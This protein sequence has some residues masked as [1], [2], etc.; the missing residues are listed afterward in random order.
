MQRF[1]AAWLLHA[2]VIA[3]ALQHLYYLPPMTAKDGS[4]YTDEE[5]IDFLV[6]QQRMGLKKAVLSRRL[7]VNRATVHRWLDKYG[8][9]ATA[10][11]SDLAYQPTTQL[12]AE[13]GSAPYEPDVGT[14]LSDLAR[15]RFTEEDM[16]ELLDLA[17]TIA[18]DV[19][20]IREQLNTVVAGSSLVLEKIT[21]MSRLLDRLR[22]AKKPPPTP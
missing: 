6:H 10:K 11:A 4:R 8:K 12:P 9:E 1:L 16:A 2:T 13:D 22:P 7:G 14:L 3:V 18:A 15:R 19:R 20:A 17:H 5:I 21:S